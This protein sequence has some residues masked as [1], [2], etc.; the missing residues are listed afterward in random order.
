MSLLGW[1]ALSVAGA[2]GASLRY[3]V[4]VA[5]SQR[6]R[7]PAPWGTWVVNVS[8]SFLLGVLIGLGLHHGL[9]RTTRVVFGVGFCGAYTTFS[10]FA[11][12]T[13]R[14]G[15]GAGRGAAARNVVGTVVGA[16]LAAAAGLALPALLGP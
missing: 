2:A 7:G 14:L 5:L 6:S 12:E 8:G 15:E 3:L 10:A 11:V 9:P 1:V 13:V 4:E 16:L